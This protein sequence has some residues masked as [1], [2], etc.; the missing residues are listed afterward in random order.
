MH[1][2][3]PPNSQV[4]DEAQAEREWSRPLIL[5]LNPRWH[6]RPPNSLPTHEHNCDFV[7]VLDITR[8]RLRLGGWVHRNGIQPDN[9][10]G[11]VGRHQDEFARRRAVQASSAGCADSSTLLRLVIDAAALEGRPR[12]AGDLGVIF[13][14][15]THIERFLAYRA[16]RADR[17]RCSGERRDTG[18][19]Q[20]CRDTP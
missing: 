15:G 9:H 5:F 14:K 20:D 16:N 7:S 11:R 13:L 4:Y 18:Y 8:H 12:G 6:K 10:P 19:A 1:G 17:R 2:W 3:Y